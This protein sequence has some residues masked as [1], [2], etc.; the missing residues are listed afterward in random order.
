MEVLHLLKDDL[1]DGQIA[2]QLHIATKT[3]SCHVS[4][5]LTKLGVQTRHQA[6]RKLAQTPR[7]ND[8]QDRSITTSE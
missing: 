3:A 2:A 5:V 6:V 8:D 1:S 4:A 7:G